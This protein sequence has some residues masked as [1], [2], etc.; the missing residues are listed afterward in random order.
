M[1]YVW[2]ILYPV[3]YLRNVSDQSIYIL[4]YVLLWSYI[5]ITKVVVYDASLGRTVL[6]MLFWMGVLALPFLPFGI[7]YM[8][9]ARYATRI[10]S[11]AL[12]LLPF[13]GL[14]VWLFLI[15]RFFFRQ[16]YLVA[17]AWAFV[18]FLLIIIIITLADLLPMLKSR[19]LFHA[20]GYRASLANTFLSTMPVRALLLSMALAVFYM[21]VFERQFLRASRGEHSRVNVLTPLFVSIALFLVLMIIRDD[22]RRYRYFNYQ[23][24]IATVYFAAYDDRQMLSFDQNQFTLASGRQS[25]F[26]PFGRFNVRDTLRKH[27]EEILRMKLIEGL[28]YYRLARIIMI[29]A[30]GPRDTVIYQKLRPVMN[31]RRYRTP[32]HFAFWAEYLDR[33]YGS[34][35]NDMIVM[36]WVRINGK[37]LARVEF[38]VNKVSFAE[39][40]NA[41]PVWHGHTDANGRFEFSCY[42]D[43]ELDSGYFQVNL[44][45]PDTMIGKDLQSLKVIHPLPVFS[46]SGKYILDT[47]NIEFG[48]RGQVSY[49]KGLTVQTSSQT[50]SFLLFIPDIE[51]GTPV[52][53]VG[54]VVESG[55]VDNFQMEYTPVEM[56]TFEQILFIEQMKT[57]RF[58]LKEAEGEL[59][60]SIY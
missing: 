15:N 13:I 39:R 40:R 30:H 35:D 44:S 48:R 51:T 46:G 43:V 53:L 47:L 27:A 17:G 56:D 10:T 57:S 29:V 28:D 25:I 6:K 52:R 38:I 45:L 32:E 36:G 5:L 21:F 33:R 24:G 11:Y 12:R 34:P 26:Y 7:E 55:R 2:Y 41:E 42:K 22:F 58:Y 50:D 23:G 1:E 14:L 20:L 31:G 16:N 4:I 60:I 37:P 54:S 19:I 59:V 49:R 18:N 8:S 3:L 9:L